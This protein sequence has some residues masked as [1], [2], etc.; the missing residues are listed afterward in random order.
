MKK[1]NQIEIIITVLLVIILIIA[2]ANSFKLLK[3]RFAKQ[4]PSEQEV[5]LPEVKPA[6]AKEGG[7]PESGE[8]FAW[9][10]DPFSGKVY[11][12]RTTGENILKL[13]GIIWDETQPLAM[14][15]GHI[16]KPGDSVDNNKV[17]TIK[18]DRVILNDGSVDFELLLGY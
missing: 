6:Q 9:V 18:K 5:A 7:A 3:E 2:S 10:R 12:D 11:R 15:S 16:L 8:T 4:K 1:N 14:I 13:D 17:V